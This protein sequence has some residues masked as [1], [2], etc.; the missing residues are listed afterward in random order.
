MK[1]YGL[2]MLTAFLTFLT[3]C[4]GSLDAQEETGQFIDKGDITLEYIEPED[5]DFQEVY[6]ALQKTSIV[7][8]MVEILNNRLALPQDIPVYFTECD[9][10]DAFYDMDSQDIS[11]CY[12]LIEEYVE[13][14]T[15]EDTSKKEYREEIAF[16][17][18]FTL[19][20]EIGHALV[21]ILEL[22]ITGRE[23][24]AVDNFAAVMLIENGEEGIEATVTGIIQFEIDAEEETEDVEDIEDVDFGGEHSLNIQ[25]FYNLSCFVYG[26][27]PDKFDY[28][29]EE[30]YLPEDRA[31]VCE[32][33]YEQ[34]VRSWNILLEDYYQ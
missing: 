3:G 31:E 24:D 16:A 9:E 27:D 15:D 22:P 7:E 28:F 23:E 5:D 12:E 4:G 2:L 21:D 33:E 10:S 34:K 30:D 17:A 18:L 8:D 11:M 20:H 6:E 13:I 14:F 29:L 19:F 32:D 1:H 26:S 25:R